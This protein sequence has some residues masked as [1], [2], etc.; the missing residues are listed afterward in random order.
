MKGLTEMHRPYL[1]HE[2]PE[3]GDKS[4]V[5]EWLYRKISKEEFNLSFGY[6]HSDTC[7]GLRMPIAN[8]SSEAARDELAEHQ[9]KASQGYQV[10]REDTDLCKTDSDLHVFSF[11]L[12]QNLPVPTLTQSSMPTL[13]V[14]LRNSRMQFWVSSDVSVE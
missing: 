9:L 10:L 11:D 3:A 7:D 4:S 13:G 5:K 6:P 14:Q 2:Q 8:T 1:A 12:Q